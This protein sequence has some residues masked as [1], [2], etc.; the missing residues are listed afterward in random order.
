M[1]P[2]WG[3]GLLADQFCNQRLRLAGFEGPAMG[4]RELVQVWGPKATRHGGMG[5]ATSWAGIFRIISLPRLAWAGKVLGANLKNV[6]DGGADM[7]PYFRKEIRRV[8]IVSIYTH[9]K[10]DRTHLAQTCGSFQVFPF[11][12][13]RA[14]KGLGEEI[15]MKEHNPTC[16]CTHTCTRTYTLMRAHTCTHIPTTNPYHRWPWVELS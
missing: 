8:N 3:P 16:V 2:E 1:R 14:T 5:Q 10:G 12:E 9:F 7:R 6:A 15:V 4:P 11:S 13:G